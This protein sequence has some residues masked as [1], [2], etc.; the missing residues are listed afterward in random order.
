L[1]LDDRLLLSHL[2]GNATGRLTDLTRRR[3]LSTTGLWYYRLCHAIQS[4]R[5]TGALSGPFAAV[6]PQIK[7]KVGVALVRLPDEMGLMSLRE[8]AP[9]M[10]DLVGRHRLIVL[11]LEALAAA[12]SLES[13]IAIAVGSENPTLQEAPNRRAF[14][15]ISWRCERYRLLQ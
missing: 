12:L 7:A 1:L 8:I 14:A 2:L 9:L 4:D 10:A 13:D 5:V 6:E 3:A 15:S 11:S